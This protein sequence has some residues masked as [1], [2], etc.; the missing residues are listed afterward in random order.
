MR[1]NRKEEIFVPSKG[2]VS[3]DEKGRRV[4]KTAK[5]VRPITDPTWNAQ[6]A[7]TRVRMS[8]KERLRQRE[9]L[10]KAIEAKKSEAS[11]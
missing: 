7:G 4:V 5:I 10:R 2:M 8:K 6:Q 9:K 3:Y 1:S 11:A